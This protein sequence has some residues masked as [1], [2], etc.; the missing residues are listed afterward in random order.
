[1]LGLAHLVEFNRRLSLARASA[2]SGTLTL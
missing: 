2:P 1:M